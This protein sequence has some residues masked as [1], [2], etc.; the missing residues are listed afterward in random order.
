LAAALLHT[1]SAASAR[2]FPSPPHFLQFPP[3]L[4]SPASPALGQATLIT[5]RV[6]DAFTG[7]PISQTFVSAFDAVSDA[8]LTTVQTDPGGRYT[9]PV[10]TPYNA[11]KLQFNA[12]APYALEWWNDQLVLAEA[13]VIS[14]TNPAIPAYDL[15]LERTGTLS[16]TVNLAGS[17]LP[18][19][20]FVTFE[21][22]NA[23]GNYIG[24][25]LRDGHRFYIYLRPGAYRLR[26]GGSVALP[27]WHGGPTFSQAV[28]L[29][30]T[31][32]G[33]TALDLDLTRGGVITGLVTS[34][35]TGR[36]LPYADVDVFDQ[37]GLYLEGPSYAFADPTGVYTVGGLSTGFY[38]LRFENPDHVPQ[39]VAG[40]TAT[41]G[42]TRT[43][44]NPALEP[45]GALTGTLTR[46]GQPI[47]AASAVQINAYRPGTRDPLASALSQGGGAYVLAVPSG[48]VQL[49]FTGPGL[50]PE[51]YP[52]QPIQPVASE[53]SVTAGVTRWQFNADLA[54][55]N[56]CLA[57]EVTT[58][59]GTLP[60]AYVL[61]FDTF[62]ER[63][64]LAATDPA[65]GYQICGLA[66]GQYRAQVGH[67]PYAI[68]WHA[69][70][71]SPDTADLIVVQAAQT[72]TV[73]ARLDAL[74]GCLRG[75]FHGPDG[76]GE[77]FS[78][79]KVMALG[80]HGQPLTFF[81][82][83]SHA[84]E[85]AQQPDTTGRFTL[86]G[87]PLGHYFVIGWV[88]GD[89]DGRRDAD[90]PFDVAGATLT[91]ALLPP[92]LD[93]ALPAPRFL[94]PFVHR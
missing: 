71:P 85:T 38:A 60:G 52:N 47:A 64:G 28:P 58:V 21:T 93:L 67:Y 68:E 37:D 23:N 49:R 86:C 31:A 59:T 62:G 54:A 44:V 36:P 29:T 43:N 56:G 27:G 5:G 89:Y 81:S 70:Q 72:T 94:L 2:S 13:G 9:L 35:L 55:A 69:D 63:A 11:V 22:Y 74:G 30:L 3:P 53:I 34:G 16:L 92:E 20:A 6:T 87:L 40:L 33:V 83:P 25:L 65:G 48:T 84:L 39:L 10:T 42:L 46:A 80:A 77:T 41:A 8:A 17:P 4:E 7:L 82:I 15:A 73:D 61:L 88:D 50:V 12:G 91:D 32:D 57:G 26:I 19:S 78:H 45:F 66:P 1:T 18:P 24:S 75:D 14:L 79:H 51:W 90:E 76:V